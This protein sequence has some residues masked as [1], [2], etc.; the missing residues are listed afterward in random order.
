MD[1]NAIKTEYITDETTSYQTLADKYGCSKHT[2]SERARAEG[3]V[4]E[5]TQY[6]HDVYTKAKG[7]AEKAAVRK[8]V[9]LS[10][11]ADQLLDK[12]IELLAVVQDPDSLKK[13]TGAAKDIKELKGEIS[14]I[15]RREQMARIAK[16]EREIAGD[17]ES[18]KTVT[19][20]LVG[21]LSKY[22]N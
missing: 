8:T 17:G 6:L 7:D 14:A 2:I 5:R 11:V 3:W 18:N 12:L 1:W 16:L 19:V 20:N 21:D 15:E 13:L 22:A 10:Y 9:K 4:Q